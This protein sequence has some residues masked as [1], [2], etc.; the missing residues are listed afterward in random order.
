M[1]LWW[2]GETMNRKVEWRSVPGYP[3]YEVNTVGEVGGPFGRIDVE[4]V[5]GSKAYILY[6]KDG[7]QFL[8]RPSE[9]IQRAFP[10]ISDEDATKWDRVL[11]TP[12]KV[13]SD[14]VAVGEYYVKRTKELYDELDRIEKLEKES[15]D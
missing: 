8:V 14:I 5:I 10:D 15:N 2:K 1:P 11:R 7:T 4:N 9:L 6:R 3:D 13:R 12:E